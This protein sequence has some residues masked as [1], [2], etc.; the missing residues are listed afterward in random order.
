MALKSGASGL[1][2]RT[3]L[4]P[5][6]STFRPCSDTRPLVL[7]DLTT[8]PAPDHCVLRPAVCETLQASTEGR[9]S[10]PVTTSNINTGKEHEARGQLRCISTLL[11]DLAKG[12][13]SEGRRVF[14]PCP[15]AVASL[16]SPWPKGN[17][18]P[19]LGCLLY[20][21]DAADDYFEV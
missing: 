21:S 15:R 1:P 17:G 2:H 4:W 9:P 13:G 3:P 20:T 18:S 8:S 5:P 6:N 14:C 7:G 11:A 16:S 10:Q 12:R 19:L